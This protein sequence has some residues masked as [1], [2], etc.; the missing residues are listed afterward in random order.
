MI[1]RLTK[2]KSKLLLAVLGF[3]LS[4]A[5]VLI[6]AQGSGTPSTLR[7]NVDALGYLVVSSA[8]QTNPIT[9]V[10]FQNARLNTDAS[11]NLLV[12]GGGSAGFAPADATYITQTT[13]ATLT[14]EQAIGALATGLLQGTTGS[15]VIT[16]TLTPSIT[17][18]TTSSANTSNVNGIAATPTDASILQNGTLAT[19]GIPVQMSP[20]TRWCG[21][22]WNSVSVAGETD[23]FSAEVLPATVAGTTTAQWL[24]KSSIAGGAYT[25]RLT[26]DN[27]G[28]LTSGGAILSGSNVLTAAAS[29]VG[30]AARN[31]FGSTASGITNAL[32]GTSAFGIQFNTG[33]AAPTVTSCGT[34]TVLAGSR[35]TAGEITATGATTCTVTFGSPAWTNA[36]FCVALNKTTGL[37]PILVTTTTTTAVT[38]TNLTSNDVFNYIC[39]GRI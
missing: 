10:V 1:S 35:N 5:G 12:T 27:A 39:V 30:H 24:L 17:S 11:G 3:G 18:W 22:A 23:C 21:S 33:T 16:S 29:F 31:R 14:A 9:Q 19:A 38:F 37:L 2:F 36:P 7:V 4:T 15:G 8:A 26:I 28:L 32:D 25:T 6:Q 13:N 34:G 20:R